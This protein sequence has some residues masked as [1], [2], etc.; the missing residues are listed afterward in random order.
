MAH[1]PNWI[2]AASIAALWRQTSTRARTLILTNI[3]KRIYVH[4]YVCMYEFAS[5]CLCMYVRILIDTQALIIN[6]ETKWAMIT[7]NGSGETLE[8]FLA[9][10]CHE[11]EHRQAG[12]QSGR[13]QYQQ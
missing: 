13:Q 11:E 8:S 3:P 10:T 12:R 6:Y 5:D 7:S 4:K 2:A 1:P 9:L